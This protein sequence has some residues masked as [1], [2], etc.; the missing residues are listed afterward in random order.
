MIMAYRNNAYFKPKSQNIQIE[1]IRSFLFI[2]GN[3]V[4]YF[5][6]LNFMIENTFVC[7]G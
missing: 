2:Y 3:T 6:L 5:S 7:E 4:K 1:I